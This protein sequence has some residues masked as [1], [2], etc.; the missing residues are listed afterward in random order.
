MGRLTYHIMESYLNELT[1]EFKN[2]RVKNIF[3]LIIQEFYIL[4]F[5]RWLWII[6]QIISSIERNVFKIYEKWEVKFFDNQTKNEDIFRLIIKF[7]ANYNEQGKRIP[8]VS[9][10]SK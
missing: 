6:K 7:L 3:Q 8:S 4:I 2:I 9:L 1:N 5:K 10:D